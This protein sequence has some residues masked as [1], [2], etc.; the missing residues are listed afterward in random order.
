MDD[1][2]LGAPARTGQNSHENPAQTQHDLTGKVFTRLTVLER[3]AGS[4]IKYLCVCTCGNHKNI[5]GG[6]LISG[7]TKSCGCLSKEIRTATST[8]HGQ[9]STSEYRAWANMWGRCICTHNTQY[10]RYK[11]RTPPEEWKDFTVFFA[12]VGPKPS[13][14]HSLDRIDNDKPYGPG[15]VR[16]ATANEQQNN[17]SKNRWVTYQD[18]TQTLEQWCRETG[19]KFST[20]RARLDR[21]WSVEKAL[22]QPANHRYNHH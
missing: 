22:T 5:R 13:P 8:V 9:Y 3:L 19:L 7:A 17:T 11:D 18:K 14:K 1:S 16:W 10:H 21:G 6:A 20:L 12:H 2:T 4:P 15:N